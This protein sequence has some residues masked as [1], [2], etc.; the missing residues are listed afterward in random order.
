MI[1]FDYFKL[2]IQSVTGTITNALLK[3]QKILRKPINELIPA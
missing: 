2:S 1:Q 3:L